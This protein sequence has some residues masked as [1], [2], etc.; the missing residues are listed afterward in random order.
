[1]TTISR[2]PR[3]I[4]PVGVIPER[5]LA[6]GIEALTLLKVRRATNVEIS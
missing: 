4:W 1:M 3:G 5:D 6:K 2:A